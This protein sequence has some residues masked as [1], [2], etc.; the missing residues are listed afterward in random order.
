MVAHAPDVAFTEAQAIPDLGKSRVEADRM[1]R[2]LLLAQWAVAVVIA[3][4]LTPWANLGADRALQVHVWSVFLLGGALC[5]TPLALIARRPGWWMTRHVV[6]ATQMLFSALLIHVTGGRVESHFHVFASLAFLAFYRDWTVLATA[7][8]FVAADH[9]FRGMLWP[10]SVYGIDDPEWWRFFEHAAWVVFVDTVLLLGISRSLRDLRCLGEREATL[11]EVHAL[12]ERQVAERTAELAASREQFRAL[13]ESTQAISWEFVPEQRRS[14]YVAPQIEAL[15]GYPLVRYDEPD[16]YRSVVHTEDIERFEGAMYRGI[17][18]GVDFQEELRLV[19]T[20]G[21]VLHIRTVVTVVPRGDTVVL[22]GVM[23]DISRQKLLEAELREAHKLESIGRLAAGVAH[24][25]NTPLQYISNNVEFLALATSRLLAALEAVGSLRDREQSVDA[26]V[27]E[28]LRRAKLGVL[29]ARLPAAIAATHDGLQAVERIVGTLQHLNGPKVPTVPES[30]V[31][32]AH[33]LAT[34]R[35][36]IRIDAPQVEVLLTIE[37]SVDAVLGD[38]ETLRQALAGLVRNAAE[39]CIESG[40]SEA[41]VQII[42]LRR[43]HLVE[44]LIHDGGCGMPEA[45]LQRIFDPFFT[46]KGVG[47]GCG[48]GLHRIRDVIIGEHGGELSCERSSS[49]GTTFVVR[50]AATIS[51]ARV[52]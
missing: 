51:A 50:L 18:E 2:W 20:D 22:R 15:L 31:D 11:A 7:T 12:V 27:V 49:A 43:A 38:P 32:V 46:T 44:I 5:V 35:E 34:V 6:A 16:F 52:A 39:A 26:R 47:H 28:I 14:S 24:G 8:V 33:T 41:R 21:R 42:A 3:L 37:P 48:E 36:A 9:L 10:H 13:V 1:F 40:R 23:F 19:A 25:I 30:V 17:I 29:E 45:V 4:A